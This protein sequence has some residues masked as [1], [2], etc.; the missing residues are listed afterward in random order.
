MIKAHSTVGDSLAISAAIF[1][2]AGGIFFGLFSCGGMAWYS[3]A[4]ILLAALLTGLSVLIPGN[5]L[6]SLW[7]RAAFPVFVFF[8]FIFIQAMAA[9]FYP[10]A[11]ESAM[12]YWASAL[13]VLEFGPC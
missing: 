1:A 7:R 11:P 5:F 6:Q 3:Q 9:P 13:R 4:F 2:A 8:I 12:D 10:S